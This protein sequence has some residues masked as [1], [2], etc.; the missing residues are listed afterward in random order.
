MI[1]F[2]NVHVPSPVIPVNTEK[3]MLVRILVEKKEEL[4]NGRS[5]NDKN[6]QK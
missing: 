2:A 3:R 5:L 4:V 1:A 6:S